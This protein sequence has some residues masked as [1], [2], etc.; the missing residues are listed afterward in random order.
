MSIERESF[1]LLLLFEGEN[2]NR[3]SYN[4]TQLI[5]SMSESH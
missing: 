2:V 4:K 1:F 3:E 5:M